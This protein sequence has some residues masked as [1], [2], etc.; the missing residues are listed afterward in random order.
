[1]STL[2]LGVNIDHVA[3]IR[4]ARGESYPDPSRAAEVA[5]LAGADGITAHLREDRRHI[6]DA[7][8]VALAALTRKRGR[9]LNFEMAATDEMEAIAL[10]HRPHAACL[11]PERR[12]EVTTEGGLDVVGQHNRLAPLVANLRAAGIRVS[13]F[14]EPDLRQILAAKDI[15][16][17]VVELHTGA[18]CLAVRERSGDAKE[19]LGRLRSAAEQAHSLGLEVH[20]GHGIDFETV[21]AI[22]AIPWVAELN[23]GHFLIGEAIFTGLE[24]AIRRMRAL[25]EGARTASLAEVAA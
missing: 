19:L 18:Y 15:G 8:I 14:V 10:A 25:M 11:V 2:R 5:M 16:A 3:T 22:A 1:M 24:Q 20:A 13:V 6:S 12:D 23:I 17:Q 9:P 21:G 7:D 4:N